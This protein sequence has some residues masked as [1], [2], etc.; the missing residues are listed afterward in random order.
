VN[1]ETIERES[2]EPC[3]EQ[4]TAKMQNL[5]SS[6]IL[7]LIL[8]H[9]GD[10]AP[11]SKKR[12]KKRQRSTVPVVPSQYYDQS[13]DGK[14]SCPYHLPASQT[15]V[16][17]LSEFGHELER[18]GRQ[19]EAIRCYAE[20][21]HVQPQTARGWFDLAVAHQHSHP[22]Q[23]LRFYQHGVSLEPSAFH[24]NQLGVMLRIAA[25]HEEAATR[26]TQSARLAPKD[27]DALF[28]LGGT[29]ETLSHHSEALH[30]YRAALD[31]EHKN[32]AR[33][34]NNMGNVLGRIE[35]WPEALSNYREALDADPDFPETQQ[36]LAHVMEQLNRLDEAVTH[37]EAAARLLPEQAANLTARRIA[38]IE[39]RDEKRKT[40]RAVER[41]EEVNKRDGHL[42]K[43]QRV[44]R[45]QEVVSACGMDKQCM[46]RALNQE[47]AQEGDMVVF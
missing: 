7:L 2:E 20:A 17:E 41:R 34:H 38:L 25:R 14:G 18:D 45:F 39:K 23:A 12:R 19:P 37:L 35:R 8:V 6:F 47:D 15:S 32:E 1:G 40:Q 46:K 4:P 29:H 31:C 36:N 42:S 33:I 26:F 5:G 24:Y 28:N 43:E 27:A 16:H 9:T 22:E 44:Q 21:V 10:S 13:E 30:A 11:S 3:R